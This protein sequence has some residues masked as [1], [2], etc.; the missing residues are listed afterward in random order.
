MTASSSLRFRIRPGLI[1]LAVILVVSY[2]IF[3]L[4][5]REKLEDYAIEFR[6]NLTWAIFQ[7][8]KELT[9][10][11]RLSEQAA[12]GRDVSADDLLLSFDI[13]VSRVNLVIQGDGFEE[14]RQIEPVKETLDRLEQSIARIDAAL[15]TTDESPAAIAEIL[16]RVL[17]DFEDDLQKISLEAIHYSSERNTMRNAEISSQMNIL[18]FLFIG[19]L[20][21]IVGVIV[22]AVRQ[23]L[24]AYNAAFKAEE[25]AMERRFIEE[26]AERSKLEALGSLAGGVAHEIN[27]PAQYVTANLDFLKDAFNDLTRT[28]G[29]AISEED[30]AYYRDEVPAA[31]SQSSE[32]MRQVAVIVQAIKH[33]AH[34]GEGNKDRVSIPDEIRNAVLL[35]N[36]QIKYAVDVSTD[37]DPDLPLVVGRPNELNQVLINLI[38]N[39]SYAI[40]DSQ[41][42]TGAEFEMGRISISAKLHEKNIEIR[43]HDN[44]P[45][46]PKDLA[47]RVFDPFFTTKPVGVGT[48]QGLAISQRIVFSTFNG[49]LFLDDSVEGACFVIQLPVP[50]IEP[51]QYVQRG[52]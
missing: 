1:F 44:G 41:K 24:K 30:L 26:T 42:S 19:N 35:T 17:I 27:T 29:K 3:T 8:Q 22:I 16:Y 52:Q 37:I 43:V 36:N 51:E 46:V 50:D 11:L 28:D 6:E 2:L 38:M 34:P 31:I 7:V 20:V 14:L 39:A 10:T 12:A 49:K 21:I 40:E 48:G 32:G 23:A 4:S 13:L 47:K 9:N 15:E 5:F 25:Q 33:F 18:Q 45:G